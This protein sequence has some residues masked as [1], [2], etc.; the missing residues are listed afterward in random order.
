MPMKEV[1]FF[2]GSSCILGMLQ[3]ESGRFNK[4][5][6]TRVSKIKVKSDV[7]KKGYWIE[8][9]YNTA[10]LGTRDTASAGEV[11]TCS[12]YQEGWD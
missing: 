10:D 7:L 11:G 2:T 6:G 9:E 12:H 8:G 1:K 4:L 5:T 3:M